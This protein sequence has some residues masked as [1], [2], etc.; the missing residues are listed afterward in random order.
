MLN[1]RDVFELIGDGFDDGT[2]A[3]K[4]FIRPVEQA[5]VHLLTQLGDEMQSMSHHQVLGQW[6]GEVAFVPKELADESFCQLGNGMSIINVA[7]GQTK[8]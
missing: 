2:F 1:L 7:R 3:Q 6:L 8:G 4:E 5:V